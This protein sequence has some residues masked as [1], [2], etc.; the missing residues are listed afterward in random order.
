MP[1]KRKRERERKRERDKYYLSKIFQKGCIK[2]TK[3]ESIDIFIATK[4]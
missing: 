2:L 3:I 4:N 1:C